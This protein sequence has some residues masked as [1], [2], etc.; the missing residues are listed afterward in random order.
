VRLGPDAENIP[1]WDSLLAESGES[2]L[3][4]FIICACNADWGPELDADD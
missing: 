2:W 3:P 1:K 4:V